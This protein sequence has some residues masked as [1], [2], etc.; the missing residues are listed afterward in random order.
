MRPPRSIIPAGL[1]AHLAQMLQGAMR[2]VEPP[3]EV[4]RR[5]LRAASRLEGEAVWEREVLYHRAQG[6]FAI[7]LVEPSPMFGW[8]TLPLRQN[9]LLG[10]PKPRFSW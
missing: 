2:T 9:Y 5:L 6:W 7:H 8:M 10:F 1:D 4:R 3:V